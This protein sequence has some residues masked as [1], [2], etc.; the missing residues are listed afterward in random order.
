MSSSTDMSD[1]D[2]K[3]ACATDE[4]QDRIYRRV[5]INISTAGPQLILCKN[6]IFLP[7]GADVRRLTSLR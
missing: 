7:V 5:R 4:A 3:T 1:Q 2:R 6:A